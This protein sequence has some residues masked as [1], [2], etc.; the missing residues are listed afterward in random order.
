MEILTLS[1]IK[2]QY[3]DQWVLLGDPEI[4]KPEINGALIDKIIRGTV[5]YASKDK[6]EIGFKAAEKTPQNVHKTAC[7][8]TGKKTKNRLFL[9]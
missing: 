1:Q 2:L 3:P 4:D 5:I 9:L 6:R 8:Y 7:I